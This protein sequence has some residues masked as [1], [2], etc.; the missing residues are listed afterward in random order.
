TAKP[1]SRQNEIRLYEHYGWP[2]NS[3]EGLTFYG[4]I[5]MAGMIDTRT[6]F[7]ENIAGRELEGD[8]EDTHLRGT[9]EVRRFVIH[10]ID[11][12]FGKVDDFLADDNWRIRFMVID[13]G[14]WF[15]GK[16]VLMAP[17]WINKISWTDSMVYVDIPKESIRNSPEYDA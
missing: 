14:N 1:V 2:F 9:A 11:G 10:A 17:R 8:Q 16:R 6:P 7:E 4:G 13:T 5:G 3:I 15:S 12:E